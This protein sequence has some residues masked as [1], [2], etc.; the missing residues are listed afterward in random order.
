MKRKK[1]I[2]LDIG[3][4]S[5][6]Y[7]EVQTTKNKPHPIVTRAD[8]L[9]FDTGET[10][11][12]R[13]RALRGALGELLLR[14]AKCGALD[15]GEVHVV[16]API[17]YNAQIDSMRKEES[18]AFTITKELLSELVSEVKREDRCEDVVTHCTVSGYPTTTPFNKETKSLETKIWS[19][20]IV[21]DVKDAIDR[22]VSEHLHREVVAYHSHAL[23]LY[24]ATAQMQ[25]GKG[26]CILL[27][28]FP[29]TTQLLYVCDGGVLATCKGKDGRSVLDEIM[30]KLPLPCHTIRY[31]PAAG[32]GEGDLT[33]THEVRASDFRGQLELEGD[34][35][36]DTGLMLAATVCATL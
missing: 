13:I 34:I 3:E 17:Y 11:G 27:S 7:V 18:E 20:C 23:V 25:L 21:D 33:V 8:R 28:S 35:A 9:R 30:T 12:V 32:T 31:R 5:V 6:G 19:L 22:V 24:H 26:N 16:L 36:I 2:V 14:G 4:D 15:E 10:F 1:F 29:A